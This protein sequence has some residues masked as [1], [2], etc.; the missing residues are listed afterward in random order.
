MVTLMLELLFSLSSSSYGDGHRSVEVLYN[1]REGR[2]SL[3]FLLCLALNHSFADDD[4]TTHDTQIISTLYEQT[5]QTLSFTSPRL[6]TSRSA[7]STTNENSQLSVPRFPISSL[8]ESDSK[9]GR[10]GRRSVCS[11]IARFRRFRMGRNRGVRRFEE[12]RRIPRFFY[13]GNPRFGA[14]VD[15]LPREIPRN[16]A[17][18]AAQLFEPHSAGV[19]FRGSSRNG[20]NVDRASDRARK[21]L[22]FSVE[23]GEGSEWKARSAGE[24]CG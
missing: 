24:Y 19:T 7:T 20:E 2:I 5:L 6:F 8:L 4:F 12:S 14:A 15:S 9:P 3:F 13:T 10:S 18:N 11:Q 17:E 23:E 22:D 1:G 16:R 21:R